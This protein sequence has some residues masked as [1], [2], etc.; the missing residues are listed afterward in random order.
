MQNLS[1]SFW[2]CSSWFRKRRLR[3]ARAVVAVVA[4]GVVG[5]AVAVAEVVAERGCPEAHEEAEA[6][7]GARAE[8]PAVVRAETPAEVL[9]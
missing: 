7:A 5:E 4:V 1:H 2:P 6:P 8:T 9:R 3:A